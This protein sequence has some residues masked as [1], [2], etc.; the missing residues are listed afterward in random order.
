MP[1]LSDQHLILFYP[2]G[3]RNV[4]HEGPYFTF[5]ARR[6]RPE[7]G[8]KLSPRILIQRLQIAAK[9][10]HDLYRRIGIQSVVRAKLEKYP[11]FAIA[12]ATSLLTMA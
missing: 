4:F 7:A 8:R 6:D 1:G 12:M 2:E 3:V 5:I 10:L 9:L 11:I